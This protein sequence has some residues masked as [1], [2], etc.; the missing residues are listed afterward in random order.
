MDSTGARLERQDNLE[1][2]VALMLLMAWLLF[3]MR[4]F[5]AEPHASQREKETH[6]VK[7]IAMNV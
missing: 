6:V 1:R 2:G 3:G 5:V 4:V 7:I